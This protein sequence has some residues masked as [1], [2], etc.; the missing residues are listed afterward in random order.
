MKKQ[1]LSPEDLTLSSQSAVS[2]SSKAVMPHPAC[3]ISNVPQV[4]YVDAEWLDRHFLVPGF[5][6]DIFEGMLYDLHGEDPEW[7]DD[8]WET[9]QEECRSSFP[10]FFPASEVAQI[11]GYASE[12]E[13]FEAEENEGLFFDKYIVARDRKA[14]EVWYRNLDIYSFKY[15]DDL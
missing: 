4:F 8:D 1:L 7:S 2:D 11:L 10:T 13:L 6:A 3:T 9:I 15:R 14:P 12:K 5:Y